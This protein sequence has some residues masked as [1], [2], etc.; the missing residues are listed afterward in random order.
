MAKPP[1][2]TGRHKNDDTTEYKL[3]LECSHGETTRAY[4][5]TQER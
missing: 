1:V 5:K 4:R 3:Y 2:L